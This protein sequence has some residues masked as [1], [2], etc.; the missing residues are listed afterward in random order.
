MR[1]KGSADELQARRFRA[2]RLLQ[3]GRI[4]SEVARLLKI[5]RSSVSRWQATYARDRNKLAAKPRT[6][7]PR[8]DLKRDKVVD[9]LMRELLKGAAHHG[10]KGGH[11]TASRVRELLR[12]KFKVT[13]HVEHVR[14]LMKTL[15]FTRHSHPTFFARKRCVPRD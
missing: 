12:R 5:H 3:K 10:F 4:A 7:H 14:Y 8:L 9:K 15:R 1:P 13:Y 6:C 11:W 2:M